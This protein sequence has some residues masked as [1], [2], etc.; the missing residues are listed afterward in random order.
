[1]HMYVRVNSNA[2]FKRQDKRMDEALRWFTPE[3]PETVHKGGKSDA[4]SCLS[5][6]RSEGLQS[7]ADF[8]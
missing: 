2:V 3:L 7:F 5:M 6:C 1:M 4:G 8:S